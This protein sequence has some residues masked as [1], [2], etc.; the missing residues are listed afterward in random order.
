MLKGFECPFYHSGKD[1]RTIEIKKADDREVI[2]RQR[3]KYEMCV[4]T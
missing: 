3:K 1:K 4:I 2:C